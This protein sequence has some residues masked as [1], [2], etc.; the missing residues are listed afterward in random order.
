VIDW[1]Q[2]VMIH[3]QVLLPAEI[4]VLLTSA[5]GAVLWRRFC[6]PYLDQRF[7]SYRLK[8]IASL[9]A[10]ISWIELNCVDDQNR[11]RTLIGYGVIALSAQISLVSS[12]ILAELFSIS[13][14]IS[15][16]AFDHGFYTI[17]SVVMMALIVICAI[18][19]YR[20]SERFGSLI[21][22]E[23]FKR[24]YEARLKRLEGLP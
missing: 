1:L 21:N 17:L 16:N 23:T 15:A 3:F 22:F 4:L 7:K 14:K 2:G 9:R 6:R 11:L 5:V 20:Y 19:S 10:K 24:G 18:T 13:G 8:T 12:I